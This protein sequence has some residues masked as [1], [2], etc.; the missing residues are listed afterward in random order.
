MCSRFRDGDGR[1]DS[2]SPSNSGNTIEMPSVIH[3]IP[4]VKSEKAITRRTGGRAAVGRR[5][6]GETSEASKGPPFAR[7]PL[8]RAL[9]AAGG[10]AGQRLLV[11]QETDSAK[12]AV[13]GL[14]IFTKTATASKSVSCGFFQQPS[15]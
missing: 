8:T 2:Y 7:Q 15:Q 12:L 11:P 5:A 10:L 4:G 14:F 13:A 3:T 9:M 6:D 1:F